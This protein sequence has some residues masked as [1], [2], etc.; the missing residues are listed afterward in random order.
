MTNSR[1]YTKLSC[2]EA[3]QMMFYMRE[4]PLVS[5]TEVRGTSL[6]LWLSMMSWITR[7]R[8]YECT[9]IEFDQ[10]Y[11]TLAECHSND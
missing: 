7:C 8:S 2:G 5:H 11:K 6:V 1:W 4:E 3:E 9:K 10:Y